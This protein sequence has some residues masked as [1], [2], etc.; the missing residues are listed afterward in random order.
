MIKL[1]KQILQL[2]NV[3]CDNYRMRES[4]NIFSCSFAWGKLLFNEPMKNLP[5]S[6]TGT[7]QM[8]IA[9]IQLRK[10]NQ[11]IQDQALSWESVT[12]LV[13]QEECTMR[14]SDQREDDFFFNV[15][16]TGL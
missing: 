7:T 2:R 14:P 3:D 4:F 13:A 6:L 8:P 16:N 11:Q 12:S 10:Y 5:L 9:V 15:A 1:I